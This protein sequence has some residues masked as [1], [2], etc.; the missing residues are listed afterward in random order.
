MRKVKVAAFL[1][2]CEIYW[3][4]LAQGLARKAQLWRTC[5]RYIAKGQGGALILQRALP[6]TVCGQESLRT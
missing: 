1:I 2:Q 5:A 3:S 4:S 6:A